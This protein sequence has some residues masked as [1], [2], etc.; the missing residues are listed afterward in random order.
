MGENMLSFAHCTKF[1][2]TRGAAECLRISPRDEPGDR[3]AHC[4]PPPA[5]LGRHF[6]ARAALFLVSGIGA[7]AET[8]WPLRPTASGCR[9]CH[10]QGLLAGKKSNGER[11]RRST[12]EGPDRWKPYR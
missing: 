10:L 9:P 8:T 11:L 7:D 4:R 6:R 12:S 2:N 1:R 3:P 5:R